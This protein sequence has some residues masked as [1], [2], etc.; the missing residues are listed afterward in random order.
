MGL[1]RAQIFML[2]LALGNDSLKAKVLTRWFS[3]CSTA[4]F[5]FFLGK[6]SVYT[7]QLS[8]KS[9]F[10]PSTTKPDNMSH[11]LSKS[12]EFG[13]WGGFEGGFVFLKELNKSN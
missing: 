7:L 12:G 13:P 9:D 4:Q 11:Q 8:Q 6:N 1:K 3:A 2:G 10:Q 5:F